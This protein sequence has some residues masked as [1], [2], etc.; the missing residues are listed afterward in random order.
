MCQHILEE[1][2]LSS[3]VQV[4]TSMHKPILQ[5]VVDSDLSYQMRHDG[6]AKEC[7]KSIIEAAKTQPHMC[8]LCV[9]DE[10]GLGETP[11]V[12]NL[13][14][15]SLDI[16]TNPLMKHFARM[17]GL[18]HALSTSDTRL[19]ESTNTPGK[20]SLTKTLRAM[21]DELAMVR[22]RRGA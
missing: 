2:L 3:T 15:R 20:T 6:E 17:D 18:R 7:M 19:A 10:F 5:Y 21:D 9:D 4:L 1:P 12:Y 22:R 8:I 11:S 16:Y 14:A 13:L